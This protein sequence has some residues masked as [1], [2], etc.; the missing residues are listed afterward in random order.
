MATEAIAT[1]YGPA[2]PTLDTRIAEVGFVLVLLL[3]IV[4]LTPFDVR[5]PAALAA[6]DAATASG[7]AVRQIAFLGTF[8]LIVYGAL[9]KR[10]VMAVTAIPPMIA[11]L[12]GWCMLSSLWSGETDVVA[13]RAVL[14]AIFVS[15]M[16]LS[17]DTL[18]ASRTIVIWRYAIGAI[19][20][21]DIASSLLIHGAVHLPDD[22]ES[23]LA[24]SWRGLH[25]HKN[26]AGSVAAS[27][28]IMFLY[29]A[30]ETRKWPDILMCAASAV[31]LVMTR[32]KSSMGLLPVALL[33]GWLYRIAWRNTLDRT[34]AAVGATLL[35]GMFAV[36]VLLEWNTIARYLEDPQNFTGRAEIWAAEVAYIQD[37]PLFGAG[38]GTFGNTGF[39]SPIYQYVGGGWVA[40]IGEGH[41]GYLEMFVTLGSIG[42][43]IGMI[44]LLI[45]PFLQFWKSD[46]TENNVNGMMFSLFIFDVLHNFMESD[47]VQVTSAQWGQMLMVIALL[48]VSSREIRERQRA[49]LP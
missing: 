5:T 39:R 26:M 33:A 29:F 7:D 21:G 48:N 20:L 15:S 32:S 17:V 40:H 30:I 37:H 18:G 1:G 13:R 47:F 23:G 42:F 3:I 25:S 43:A 10:G 28:V 16:L 44:A 38:F 34:I 11:L 31:F 24:G 27:A 8:A 22:I 14:C 35:I 49:A 45:Q 41:S 19:I 36:G 9:R 2:R 6:R 46:R 12:L 4:G